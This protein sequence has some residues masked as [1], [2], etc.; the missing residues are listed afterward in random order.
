MA[1]DLVERVAAKAAV[2]RRV[3]QTPDGQELMRILQK[4]FLSRLEG[5]EPHEII[6]NAGRADVIAY[7]MQ[8]QN[9]KE[10]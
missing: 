4:E 7:L 5:K 1:S 10:P 8:I 9:F 3:F 2:A 6:F